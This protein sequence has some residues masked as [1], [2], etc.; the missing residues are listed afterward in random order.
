MSSRY[1]MVHDNWDPHLVFPFVVERFSRNDIY[2]DPMWGILIER[3]V[4]DGEPVAAED[5]NLFMDD[6]NFSR[7]EIGA[8]PFVYQVRRSN[9]IFARKFSEDGEFELVQ[10]TIPPES[11]LIVIEYRLRDS[12]VSVGPVTALDSRLV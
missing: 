10:F 12:P 6:V 11:K 7:I 5:C 8:E 2:V 4:A 1:T 9:L 3:I